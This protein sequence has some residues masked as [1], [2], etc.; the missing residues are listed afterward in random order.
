MKLSSLSLKQKEQLFRELRVSLTHHSNAI[1]GVS[2]TYGE[3]KA[4]L[5]NGTTAGGKPLSEQLIVLGFAKAYDVVVRE[6]SNPNS[7]FDSNFIK[8]LHYIMFEDAL[9]V[10][11]AFVEKPIGAY[12]GDERT[13]KGVDIKLSSPYKISQDIENLLFRYSLRL[14]IEDI[15]SF[16]IEFEKI[17]P[18]ADGNGRIGRLLMAWQFIQ[19]DLV[20]PLILNE[21][22]REYLDSLSD[23]KKLLK[24]LKVSQKESYKLF[25]DI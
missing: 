20:P 16:H 18:F 10:S 15:A 1:E 11:S 4:L 7:K 2:L 3:T 21:Q 5:E 12:R 17:H 9:K 24:F 6:A 19:N 8:D 22:R 13:I 23:T 25:E 14:T